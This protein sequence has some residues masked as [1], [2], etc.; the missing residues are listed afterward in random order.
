MSGYISQRNT[1]AFCVV[2]ALSPLTHYK[3]P[4]CARALAFLSDGSWDV[5][6]LKWLEPG[7]AGQFFSIAL[8]L[9]INSTDQTECDSFPLP[10]PLHIRLSQV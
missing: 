3:K 5:T 4:V 9:R 7:R 10:M 2:A 8:S 1:Q 6:L